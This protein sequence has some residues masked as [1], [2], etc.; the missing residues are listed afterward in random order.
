MLCPNCKKEIENDSAFCEHCG[1]RIKKSKKGLW[2]ILMTICL[3][4]LIA[5]MIPSIK[6]KQ[7]TQE[8]LNNLVKIELMQ[9]ELDYKYVDLGLP[10]GTLWKNKNEGGR[11][12]AYYTYLDAISEFGNNLPNRKQI[13]ELRDR[14]KWEWIGYGYKVT[15][16]NRNYIILPVSGCDSEGYLID[17]GTRGSC[18]YY[19]NGGDDCSY[20]LSFDLHQITTIGYRNHSTKRSVRLVK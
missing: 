3:I 17:G 2:I 4:T 15:G 6:K 7:C 20:Y 19:D 14:C 13:L 12:I 8:A 16:P 1:A 9:K 11:V 5:I 18:W 10:S